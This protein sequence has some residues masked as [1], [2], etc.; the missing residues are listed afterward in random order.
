MAKTR[1]GQNEGTKAVFRADG[2]FMIHVSVGVKADG[3][4]DRRTV[5]G[6]TKE[7]AR[8]KADS[9]RTNFR[10]GKVAPGDA[11]T[12]G[13]W[14]ARW[15]AM[16]APHVAKTTIED[17]T[18]ILQHH[19]VTERV[20]PGADRT[21]TRLSKMRLQAVKRSDLK[22]LETRLTAR[23][24]SV[25]TRAKAIQ[26]VAAALEEALEQELIAINPA[27]KIRV[28]A[29]Q[30]EAQR[31]LTAT[32]KALTDDSMFAFLD[33]AQGDPLYP[34][35][36]V[37]FSLGLRRGEALGL[38]WQDVDFT[39]GE[40]RVIQQIRLERDSSGKSVPATAPLKTKNSRR[41]MY[42]SP[43]LLEVLQARRAVQDEHRDTLGDAWTETG[44]VFTTSL[45][46]ILN[47]NN[48]NRTIAR[49]CDT[50]GLQRFS[51]HTGRH[52]AISHALRDGQKLE[53]ISALAGHARPSITADL[54]RTVFESE[55]RL[56]MNDLA[57]RR[58]LR[59]RA[60]A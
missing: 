9:L 48:V 24:L 25:S 5:Y 3:R 28:K 40:I 53:V 59:V 26:Y 49:I 43:D 29:T 57:A 36:H 56:A 23:S 17:Y 2:R 42:A 37:L 27:R 45:G 6:A 11:I 1:R 35:F 58:A 34:V 12:L 39:T 52:T 10:Q 18:D 32:Q 41:T 51:S 46:T 19:V 21:P 22:A 7:E 33:A 15:L 20:G 50:A 38:R 8:A 55:K 16:K 31:R 44:L 14:L 4:R 47:P 60:I 54:Y 13:E 30:A